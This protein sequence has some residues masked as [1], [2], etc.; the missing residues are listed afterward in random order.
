MIK[1]ESWFCYNQAVLLYG[2][3]MNKISETKCFE[4]ELCQ[5]IDFENNSETGL[6]GY[7][8]RNI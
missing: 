5:H 3:H 6:Y 8:K 1:T 4:N 7:T 2:K